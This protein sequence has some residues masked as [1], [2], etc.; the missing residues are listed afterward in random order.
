MASPDVRT[1]QG[2]SLV[3]ARSSVAPGEVPDLLGRTRAQ[4]QMDGGASTD[5]TL[6]E[7]RPANGGDQMPL[8][9]RIVPGL[10]AVSEI[11]IERPAALVI[12]VPGDRMV[13]AHR[14]RGR[15]VRINE[16]RL[17]DRQQDGAVGDH[18]EAGEERVG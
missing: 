5:R 11:H 4:Y 8:E 18:V 1:A 10:R 6:P 12:L 16:P 13:G 2:S 7:R 17:V 15:D 9:A 14:R 3:L